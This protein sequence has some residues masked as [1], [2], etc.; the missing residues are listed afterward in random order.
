[1][2]SPSD[3]T[4]VNPVIDPNQLFT[5]PALA[6]ALGTGEQVIARAIRR[7]KLRSS[8]AIKGRLIRGA[9]VLEWIDAAERKSRRGAMTPANVNGKQR[10]AGGA[11]HP[12]A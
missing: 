7:R 3:R 1:M 2:K 9:W 4:S 6:A 8:R 5:I 12:A 10:G 11:T